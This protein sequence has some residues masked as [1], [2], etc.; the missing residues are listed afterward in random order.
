[1]TKTKSHV[2]VFRGLKSNS[3][4]VCAYCPRCDAEIKHYRQEKCD[5]CGWKI[6]WWKG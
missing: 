3:T 4:T 1:M 6:Y 2:P 5:K